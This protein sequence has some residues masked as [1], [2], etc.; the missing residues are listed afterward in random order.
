MTADLP[1]ALFKKPLLEAKIS[2]P[3]DKVSPAVIDASVT[4]NIAQVVRQNLGIDMKITLE[5]MP[6][7]EVR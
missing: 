6:P 5:D 2:V 4:D 1:D 7:T 3:A